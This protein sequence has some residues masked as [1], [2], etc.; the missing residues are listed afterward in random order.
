MPEMSVTAPGYPK[1]SLQAGIV[2]GQP[3]ERRNLIREALEFDRDVVWKFSVQPIDIDPK[4]RLMRE[5]SESENAFDPL[6]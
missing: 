4:P 3:N 6:E 1:H 2:K 5:G